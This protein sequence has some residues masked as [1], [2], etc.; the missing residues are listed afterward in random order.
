MVTVVVTAWATVSTFATW[1][2]SVT[3]RTVA[4]AARAALAAWSAFAFYVAFGLRL[5]RAHREAIF[6]GFFV[7][8]DKFDFEFVAF[9]KTGCFHVFKAV[10]GYFGDMKQSVTV[11]H[12]FYERTEIKD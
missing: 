6:A 4:F 11:G 7:N 2:V 5:E 3:T 12:E 1:A 8:L 9:L 10:P